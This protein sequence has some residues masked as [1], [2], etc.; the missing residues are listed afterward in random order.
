MST[1]GRARKGREGL[2][3]GELRT[4]S[5]STSLQFTKLLDSIRCP[6]DE[7]S[8]RTKFKIEQSLGVSIFLHQAAT[9]PEIPA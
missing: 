1:V 7:P 5:A 4:R 6:H 2:E 3:P 8:T 9:Q